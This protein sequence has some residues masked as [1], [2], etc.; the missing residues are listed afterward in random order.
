[1]DNFTQIRNQNFG[2]GDLFIA[3]SS[4]TPSK[5]IKKQSSVQTMPTENL[6]KFLE[7][8]KERLTFDNKASQKRK[9]ERKIAEVEN[10]I[11]K[12][13]TTENKTTVAENVKTGDTNKKVKLSSSNAAWG[14]V[15]IGAIGYMVG[16]TI[17]KKKAMWYAFGGATLGFVGGYS[18]TKMQQKT[19][20]SDNIIKP[21]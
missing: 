3:E 8:L 17:D 21:K 12:R 14:A 1:M 13:R 6:E 15:I 10:E 11:I 4:A 9:L 5:P 19:V 2:G 16:R 20:E 18:L 7:K